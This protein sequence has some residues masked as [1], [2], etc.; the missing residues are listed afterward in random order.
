[1]RAQWREGCAS[2][3]PEVWTAVPK[4]T[5][6][7]HR[8]A[9]GHVTRAGSLARDAQTASART[10]ARAPPASVDHRIHTQPQPYTVPQGGRAGEELSNQRCARARSR[11]ARPKASR[12]SRPRPK[13]RP[14]YA[15]HEHPPGPNANPIAW[16]PCSCWDHQGLSFAGG[17]SVRPWLLPCCGPGL[18]SWWFMRAKSSSSA[19]RSFSRSPARVLPSWLLV[20][21]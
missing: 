9:T 2:Q 14:P 16:C 21:R 12:L 13:T 18:A 8:P 1:M 10:A 5:D 20:T 6:T 11:H 17:G 7:P 4:P 15:H 19:S 3:T